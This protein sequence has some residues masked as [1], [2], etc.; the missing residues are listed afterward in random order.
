[1]AKKLSK[2][3]PSGLVL[4]GIIA[5]LGI[6]AICM[7]FLPF[8][9]QTIYGTAILGSGTFSLTGFEAGFGA[10]TVVNSSTTSLPGWT[11][12]GADKA[13]ISNGVISYSLSPLGGVTATLVIAIVALVIA[14]VS[15]AI[16]DKK[17]SGI[18]LGVVGLLFIVAGVMFFFPV[19]FGGFETSVSDTIGGK[20]GTEFSLGIGA[21][22]SAIFSLIAGLMGIGAAAISFKK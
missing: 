18:V 13:S 19:Q 9:N 16:K 17:M 11:Y 8:V 22:L 14:L 5:L 3:K 4:K 6:L 2:K 1:M 7:A 15:I 20:V 21:I 12:F 10:S